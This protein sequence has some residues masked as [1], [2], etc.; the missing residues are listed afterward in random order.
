MRLLLFLILFLFVNVEVT[1]SQSKQVII[2]KWEALSVKTDFIYKNFKSDSFYLSKNY[3][4]RYADSAE[5]LSDLSSLTYGL[6][7][8]RFEFD[9]NDNYKIQVFAGSLDSGKY[10]VDIDSGVVSIIPNGSEKL[11]IKVDYKF[12]AIDNYLIFDMS[13]NSE[14]I[15]LTLQRVA[16]GT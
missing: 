2:G 6:S 12:K 16:T 5:M 15:E 9:Q 3:K 1:F 4:T 7:M 13:E 14:F 10:H 11:K 8:Y